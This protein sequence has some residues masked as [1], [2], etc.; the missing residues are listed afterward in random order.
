LAEG[1]RALADVHRH[2]EHRA[3]HHAH[4]LALG[5]LHLVVQAAQHALAGAA[6][7]V[8]HELEFARWPR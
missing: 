5:L 7:V 8:L 1:G 6:V 3:A 2:I 4:Q